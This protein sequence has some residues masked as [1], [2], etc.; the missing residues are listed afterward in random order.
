MTQQLQAVHNTSLI[1][2]RV[3]LGCGRILWRDFGWVCELMQLCTWGDCCPSTISTAAEA[4]DGLI[5]G[6]ADVP[7]IA[8]ITSVVL[9]WASVVEDSNVRSLT[10]GYR[11]TRNELHFEYLWHVRH[12]AWTE[13]T[14]VC[15]AEVRCRVGDD[16]GKLYL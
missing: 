1:R 8:S 7:L 15:I 5:G 3:L 14:R 9:L 12:G 10:T 6:N 13:L 4:C 16:D 2:G 11:R